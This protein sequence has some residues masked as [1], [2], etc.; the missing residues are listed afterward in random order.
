MGWSTHHSGSR[1]ICML[2]RL[3]PTSAVIE[4]NGSCLF[5][6]DLH[7]GMNLP[8]TNMLLFTD[9]ILT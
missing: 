6:I 5:Q 4:G 9:E 2:A 1:P 3:H 7:F 8:Y